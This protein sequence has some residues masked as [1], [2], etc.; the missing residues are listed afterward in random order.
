MEKII[1]R[2]SDK[3]DEY[4]ARVALA[5]EIGDRPVP[6]GSD[7][8]EIILARLSDITHHLM[9]AVG[10]RLSMVAPIVEMTP[11]QREAFDKYD[12]NPTETGE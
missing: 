6:T 1:T 2:Q 9:I 3:V 10:I 11:E 7:A 12:P 5:K 8:Q 4:N